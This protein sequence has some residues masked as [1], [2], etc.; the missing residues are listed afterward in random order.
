MTF[1]VAMTESL[2]QFNLTVSKEK[3][4]A[5]LHHWT[6]MGHLMGIDKDLLPQTTDEGLYLL[7]TILSRQSTHSEEGV[8]LTKALNAFMSNKVESGIL[9]YSPH[10]LIRFLTGNTV[11][12]RIGIK[13]DRIWWFYWLLPTFLKIWFGIG[14]RLE[15]RVQSFEDFADQ[16]SKKLVRNMVWY[17]DSYKQRYF[18]VPKSLREKWFQL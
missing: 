4:D 8:L 2:K 17:F 11:A 14:E 1:S 16:A 13:S 3:E 10:V 6:I 5:Y 18:H 12:A 7:D 15:D 9:K